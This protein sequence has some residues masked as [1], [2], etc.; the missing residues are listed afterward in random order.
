MYRF[1]E[2]SGIIKTR[3]GSQKQA[4][5]ERMKR[6]VVLLFLFSIV[7]TLAYADE[8]VSAIGKIRVE[9]SGLRS[10]SGEVRVNLYNSKD[11]FPSDPKKAFLTQVVEIKDNGSK[12]I[13]ESIPSGEYAISV[14][15]DENGNK[16]VDVSWLMV[17]IEGVG[18]SNN[19]GM[20]FG[21]PGFNDAKFRIG[22]EEMDIK[23]KVRY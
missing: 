5:E 17:P 10:N 23:I 19:P 4:P 21:P 6:A 20:T 18:A 22:S 1:R 15:H 13:F 7:Y 8:T 16:K 9:I 3:H 14:L 2:L 11:G 12:A